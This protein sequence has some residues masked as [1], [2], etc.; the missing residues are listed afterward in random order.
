MTVV[1]WEE[2]RGMVHIRFKEAEPGRTLSTESDLVTIKE[3]HSLPS[4]LLHFITVEKE[5]PSFFS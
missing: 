5:H 3:E 1:T 4:D 2:E